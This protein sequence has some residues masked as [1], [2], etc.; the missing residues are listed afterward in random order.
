M[1]PT[2]AQPGE[3][4]LIIG[5][6]VVDASGE[7]VAVNAAA[8]ISTVSSSGRECFARL[9]NGTRVGLSADEFVLERIGTEAALQEFAMRCEYVLINGPRCSRPAG[10]DGSHKYKCAGEHCP[11]LTY[12]AHVL[13]HPASCTEAPSETRLAILEARGR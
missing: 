1:A 9:D 11:G 6:D 3:R 13:A 5:T 10:H 8:T 7:L 2:H 4:I 12:P